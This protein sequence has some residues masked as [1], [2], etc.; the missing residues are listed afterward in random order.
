MPADRVVEETIARCV[1][2][3]VCYHNCERAPE[4]K[5]SMCEEIREVAELVASWKLDRE[6]CKS[7]LFCVRRELQMRYGAEA[8]VRVYNEFAAVFDGAVAVPM[9]LTGRSGNR[10][11]TSASF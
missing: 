8:G 10:W 3:L 5:V 2:A 4:A 6:D 1:A 9:T 7:I 11:L